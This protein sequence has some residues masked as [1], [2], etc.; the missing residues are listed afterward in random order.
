[1]LRILTI[2]A[3]FRR[4]LHRGGVSERHPDNASARPRRLCPTYAVISAVPP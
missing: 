2:Q 3:G 1:M 4:S